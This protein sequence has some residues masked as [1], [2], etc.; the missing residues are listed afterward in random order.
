M[1]GAP[2]IPD[3]FT[4]LREDL[5]HVARHAETAWP[6]L[7]GA[8]IFLT[9]GTG[10]FGRWMVE[11]LLWANQRLGLGADLVVLSRDPDSFVGNRAP[12]LRSRPGLEFLR[13]DM[14]DFHYDGPPCSHIVHAASEANLDRDP[15]WAG[16]HLR[17]A[18]GGTM[19][20]TQ[21]AARHKPDALLV[22][23]SGAVYRDA[24]ATGNRCV[25]DHCGLD[26]CLDEKTVYGYAKRTMELL[27]AA[28]A[29]E[30]GYRAVIARC[31]SFCGPYLPLDANYA[32]G[33]FLR[34][35]MAGRPIVVSGDG[36]PLRSYLHMADLTSWLWVLLA[37][38]TSGRPYNVG[39]DQATSVA[40]LARLIARVAG[41][42]P[43]EIRGTP[44]PGRPPAAYLPSIER[45]SQELGLGVRIDLETAIARTLLWLRAQ[46][47]AATIG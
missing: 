27:V 20:L 47:R 26:D 23:T 17:T 30:S 34:D 42:G 15:C 22:L 29:A 33:N 16:R 21:M 35:A 41:G 9:G 6:A 7:R 8:R 18:L 14:T 12:H 11:S 10:F 43:V 4:L 24:P 31:F 32:L 25:E 1:P 36:T 39:G 45:A 28:G 19:R 44:V 38:G 40:E 13:G 46:Q 3:G 2:D 37:K 5:D